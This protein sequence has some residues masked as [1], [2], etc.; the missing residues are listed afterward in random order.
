MPAKNTPAQVFSNE[1][2]EIFKNTFFT[3]QIL[4]LLLFFIFLEIAV[5]GQH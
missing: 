4:W 2:C 1:I 5:E 3:E